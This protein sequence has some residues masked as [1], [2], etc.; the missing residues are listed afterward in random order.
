MIYIIGDTHFGE[1][2]I[3]KM[4]TSWHKD[5]DICDEKDEAIINSWNE[6]ITNTDTVIVAGDFGDPSY[7]GRLNGKKILIMGNHDWEWWNKVG[8]HEYEHFEHVSPYP[9]MIEN[10]YLVSHE[11]QYVSPNGVIANI[12]AH[13]H[14]NPN[15]KNASSRGY[16]VSAE[17]INWFPILLDCVIE[18]MKMEE[19]A[20]GNF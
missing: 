12:F 3:F 2:H 18:K 15:Y 19:K 1:E 11:P 13:V 6:F 4:C 9:I 5:F 17:R 8:K 16:C 14:D 7:A 10:F 20:N